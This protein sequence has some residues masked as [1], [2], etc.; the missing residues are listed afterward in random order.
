MG[1]S[2]SSNQRELSLLQEHFP[3]L[4]AF[5]EKCPVED[6]G[7]LLQDVRD[8]VKL[9]LYLFIRT[10][11]FKDVLPHPTCISHSTV[12]P[13]SLF[14]CLPKCLEMPDTRLMRNSSQID[15]CQNALY[16]HL[17]FFLRAYSMR[18]ECA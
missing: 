2:D 10:D 8:L 18:I 15:G 4:A 9:L 5:L 17:L 11:Y 16:G 12:D 13:L 6:D 1:A 14:L 3:I 7:E